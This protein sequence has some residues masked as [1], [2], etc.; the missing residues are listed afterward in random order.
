MP[1]PSAP[2]R[3]CAE[4]AAANHTT[5]AA[6]VAAN[7]LADADLIFVGQRLAIPGRRRSRVLHLHGALRATPSGSIASRHGTSVAAL[8][9]AERADE[10]EP[11][12]DRPGAEGPAGPAG[13]TRA[14]LPPVAR[15]PTSCRPGR[16]SAA[17]RP[18]TA[19]RRRRSWRPTGSPAIASTSASSSAWCRRP[20][21][22]RPRA[23]TYVV[24]SGD[25]L[26]THRPE[27]RHHGP[28]PPGRQRHPR[29]RSRRHRSHPQDPGRRHRWRRRHPLPGAGRRHVHERLGLPTLRRPVPRG[30][31]PLRPARHPRGGHRVRAPWC[32]R[33][34]SWAATR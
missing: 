22:P 21:R 12:P 19:S 25:T 29:R 20:A 34:A 11:D 31:R 32:R 16:P 30:Q 8:V 7:H 15:P 26:S 5:V 9:Q 17:S 33:S 18:A 1:T 28:G 6:L 13:T 24:R 2:A 4:I 27:V 23:T 3:P 10:P 14:R